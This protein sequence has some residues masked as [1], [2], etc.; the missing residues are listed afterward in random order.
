VVVVQSNSSAD[1]SGMKAGDFIVAVNGKPVGDR[2]ELQRVIAGIAPG[3]RISVAVIRG[4]KSKT[5]KLT[6]DTRPDRLSR[7]TPSNEPE[8]A[9]SVPTGYGLEARTLTT[10]VARALGYGARL[11]GVVI[12]KVAPGSDAAQQGLAP[13]MVIT[14]VQD[15]PVVTAKEFADALTASGERDVLLRV[16]TPGGQARF[17]VISPTE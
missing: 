13:G 8:E 15:D 11:K 16:Q 7:R 6:L 10:T 9:P 17:V 1:R 5:L 2:A 3:Q 4:G 12:A 14:H